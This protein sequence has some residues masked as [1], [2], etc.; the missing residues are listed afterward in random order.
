MFW[1]KSRRVITGNVWVNS[2][3]PR[4]ETFTPF[5]S[6]QLSKIDIC[7]FDSMSSPGALKVSIYNEEDL[8][9]PLGSVQLAS[10]G[11]G[12]TSV[13]FSSILPYLMRETM[14]RMVVS[15]EYGG[16]AGFGWFTRLAMM[17]IQ[18]GTSAGESDFT[19]EKRI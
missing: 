8:S 12:W 16:G 17:P 7:I 9:T 11:S 18:K 2:D 14:Y 3:Y 13:D 5:Y 6:G 4:Y 1:I 10:F 15:T 19:S